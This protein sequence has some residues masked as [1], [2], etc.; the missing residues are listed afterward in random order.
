[1][2]IINSMQINDWQLASTNLG[3]CKEIDY[4]VAVLG[5]GATEA[6]NYH[7]PE[8]QDFLEIDYISRRCCA[9]AWK[10]G[11]K[12]LCLPVIPFGV[13]CNQ[14]DFRFGIHVKQSVIDAMVSDVFNSLKKHGIRK[15]VIMNGHG[16]NDFTPFV[17]QF[18]C[19]SDVHVFCCDFWKVTDDVRGEIFEAPIDDHAGELETS[20]A[21]AIFPD[22]V[23]M[24]RAGGGKAAAFRFEALEKGWVKT[25]RNFGLLNDHCAVGDPSKASAEKGQKFLDIVI[26]RISRFL[27][28]LS[29]SNVDTTFPHQ[30]MTD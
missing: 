8:G 16:G 13:D 9:K 25:S 17:R 3:R 28:E 21:L 29:E 24:Q 4:E 19:D 20:V 7:L 14:A 5:I 2:D 15:F 12:V 18:Q 11:G 27:V 22:L 26:D 23:E 6:H 1:M 30:P 10:N